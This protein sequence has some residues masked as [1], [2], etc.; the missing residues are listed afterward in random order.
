ME[1]C[2]IVNTIKELVN[3]ENYK[4]EDIAILYR[5]NYLSSIKDSLFLN[6]IPYIINENR[7]KSFKIK[8]K[9]QFDDPYLNKIRKMLEEKR[10]ELNNNKIKEQN[11]VLLT[12]IH[13]IKGLEF[14]IVFLIGFE[15]ETFIDDFLHT[16]DVK[17]E[18]RLAYVAITRAKERLYITVSK[19]RMVYGDIMN[20]NPVIFLQEMGL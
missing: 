5:K 1:N 13:Q 10:K 20:L 12:T 19:E 17:E 7:E 16:I 8:S 14:K 6:K 4:Y 9:K 2:F 18:R 3:K 15:Q 11:K